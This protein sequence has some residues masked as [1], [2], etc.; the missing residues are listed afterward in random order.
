MAQQHLSD[1]ELVAHIARGER[2]AFELLY[3]RYVAQAFGLALRMMQDRATAEDIVQEAFCRVWQRATHF[4][5]Q[6]GGNV[7]AW[8]LTIVHRLAIDT[9]R[10]RRPNVEMDAHEDADWEL[11]DQ[12]ADVFEHAFANIATDRV[13][14]A[15]SQLPERHRKVIELS[16]FWG[17]T[18]R[19]I[20]EQLGEPLGTVHSWALQ[21]MNRL[22]S[23]LRQQLN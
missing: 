9:Q 10:K 23:L 5:V 20:A 18:H 15:V 19:E 21:G 14:A 7:R 2:W 22:K 4:N 16:F 6:A 11:E 12:E 3:E 13:R 17:L 8:L 1:Q